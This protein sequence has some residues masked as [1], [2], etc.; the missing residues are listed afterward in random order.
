[1]GFRRS[2]LTTGGAED[3]RRRGREQKNTKADAPN[4]GDRG[5]LHNREKFHFASSQYCRRI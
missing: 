5:D 3:R 4:A 1:M 2:S